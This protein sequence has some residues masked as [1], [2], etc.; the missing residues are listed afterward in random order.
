M[1]KTLLTAVAGISGLLTTTQIASANGLADQIGGPAAA[2]AG[3]VWLIFLSLL[4]LAIVYP[5]LRH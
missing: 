5:L 4:A 1:V 2:G 3:L